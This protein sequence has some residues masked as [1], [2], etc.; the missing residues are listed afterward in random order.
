MSLK[1]GI[2]GLPNA[3][4]NV[5]RAVG[6][7]HSPFSRCTHTHFAR[8]VVI[9]QPAFNGRVPV[10]AIVDAVK[11][12]DLLAHQHA[13]NVSTPWLLWSVD[14]DP[15]AGRAND[16]DGALHEYLVS[17]WKLMGIELT[18]IYRHCHGFDAVKDGEGFAHY[19]ERCQVET[20]MP[21]NDYW[22]TPP[23]LPTISPARIGV[24]IAAFTLG[25]TALV[26]SMAGRWGALTLPLSAALSAYVAY[27]YVTARGRKPFGTAPNSDL[28]TILKSLYLQQNFA[29]FAI[30]QQ[31]ADPAAL[32]AA[33]GQFLDT[34][35]PADVSQPTQAPGV[36]HS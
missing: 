17:L 25:V 3:D 36:I 11:N 24:A 31:G 34:H 10:D 28:R 30:A 5:R 4:Q 13:D 33:F 22:I 20:T 15:P 1:C 29:R 26:A 21:F 18:A 14:F 6:G 35:R 32:H 9:D 12:T 8:F 16:A 2:V 23:P 19:I 27:R 7:R